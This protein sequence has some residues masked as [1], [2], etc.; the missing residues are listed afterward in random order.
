MRAPSLASQALLFLAVCGFVL[1]PPVPAAPKPNIV[2]ILADDLGFSDVGCYGGEIA[3]PN[4]DNLAANGLRFSQFY[5]TARCWPTR[6]A[7]LTGHYAQSIRRDKFPARPGAG[8]SG[9]RPAWAPL[10]AQRLK[11]TGYRSTFTG[12]WHLDGKV[13]TNG[14]DHSLEIR[15]PG[16]FFTARGSFRDDQRVTPPADESGHY[17]TTYTADHVIERLKEHATQHAD[18][19]F[20]HYVAFHAPHFP[21]QAKP[22]DIDLYRDRYLDGW[23][24]LRATRFARQ[25]SLGLVPADLPLPPLEREVGPPYAHPA[26][27]T[28]LGVG[29][30]N[31]PLPWENL[32]A[33]QRRFQA[34][35]M[36]IHAA[37]VHRMDLEIGR[38][39]TQLRD[40]GAL[41]NT[42]ILFLSDNGASAEIQVSDGGHDPASP[43]GSAASFLCLGPGF[44]SACNT[45][46]R[47]HKTWVH[48]G[49]IRTPLIVHWPQGIRASGQ[50]RQAPGHVIDVV[51]TVLELAGLAPPVATADSPVL[52][53]RSLVPVFASDAIPPRAPLWWLHDGHRALR[54]DDWKLVSLQ[55]G[56]WELYNLK[57]DPGEQHNLAAAHP[58]RVR[59]MTDRWQRQTEELMAL[60]GTPAASRQS[61]PEPKDKETP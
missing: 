53:G 52:P 38:I 1:A 26:A 47:R 43:P 19:P 56:P 12:K 10:L 49:G 34:T 35:K 54:V 57:T 51:P 22:E 61:P 33:E 42:L 4:L 13:L 24:T 48:E 45:P 28:K 41:D 30:V 21:L 44:S 6:A 46:F 36:A 8:I 18:T 37:M 40:M 58:E 23:D 31:L 25:K 32:T 15:N 7:L 3:T 9:A 17:T 14:F 2:V 59:D 16:N 29:E 27:I 39:L 5:N 60:A 11:E 55:D 20:F 50:W